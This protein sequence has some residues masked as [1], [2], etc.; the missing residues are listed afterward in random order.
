MAIMSMYNQIAINTYVS[1]EYLHVCIFLALIR[2]INVI[3][4]VNTRRG[5]KKYTEAIAVAIKLIS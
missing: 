3:K 1:M 5:K 2:I 4:N